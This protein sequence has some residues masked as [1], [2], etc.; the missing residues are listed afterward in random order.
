VTGESFD[1]WRRHRDGDSFHSRREYSTVGGEN[2]S[3]T[4]SAPVLR[5]G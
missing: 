4:G 3:P 1:L 5:T 2:G